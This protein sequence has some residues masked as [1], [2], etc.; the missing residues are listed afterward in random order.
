MKWN[1][2]ILLLSLSLAAANCDSKQ[3]SPALQTKE[4]AKVGSDASGDSAGGEAKDG[5]LSEATVEVSTLTYSAKEHAITAEISY[6]GCAATQHQLVLNDICTESYPRGCSAAFQRAKSFDSSCKMLINETVVLKLED[7]F[8][9][10]NVSVKSLEK[11]K[12]VLVDKEG[13]LD[14]LMP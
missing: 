11:F 1:E 4:P 7:S 14:N 2:T 13:K 10:A 8:D 5:D 12:S 6:G 9:T 3:S